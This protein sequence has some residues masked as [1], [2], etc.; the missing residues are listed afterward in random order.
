MDRVIELFIR[1]S[2]ENRHRC[3]ILIGVKCRKNLNTKNKTRVFDF[4][5]L[6]LLPSQNILG[7]VYFRFLFFY[8][9][10]KQHCIFTIFYVSIK[11]KKHDVVIIERRIAI[12]ITS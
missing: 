4:I 3:Y 5:I 10:S 7:I 9:R 2:A 6:T 11:I 8:R 12:I 1:H